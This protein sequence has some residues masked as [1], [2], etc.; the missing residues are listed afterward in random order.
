MVGGKNQVHVMDQEESINAGPGL[1]LAPRFGAVT[2]IIGG[3]VPPP[4]PEEKGTI[5]RKGKE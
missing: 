1:K 5:V 3:P 4:T 2:K